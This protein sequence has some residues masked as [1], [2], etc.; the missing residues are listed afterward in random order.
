MRVIQA[1]IAGVALA[2]CGSA[3]AATMSLQATNIVSIRTDLVGDGGIVGY[4]IESED[5]ARGYI[6]FDL[7]A[8][9]DATQISSATLTTYG[10]NRSSVPVGTIY[11]SSDDNWSELGSVRWLNPPTPDVAFSDPISFA[12]RDGGSV[13]W[14]VNV[15]SWD[16][17]ADLADNVLTLSLIVKGGSGALRFDPRAT[18]SLTYVLPSVAPE[19]G[20]WALLILGLAAAGSALRRQRGRNHASAGRCSAIHPVRPEA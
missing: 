7:S 2:I 11:R 14:S 13:D 8:L 17:A 18:L 16:Y 19:P 15:A 3:S 12:G 4:H 6:R 10:L 9:P 5:I 20:T 1:A